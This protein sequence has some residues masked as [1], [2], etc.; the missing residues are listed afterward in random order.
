M[1][2]EQRGPNEDGADDDDGHHFQSHVGGLVRVSAAGGQP[3]RKDNDEVAE[4]QKRDGGD[5]C[6]SEASAAGRT[7]PQDDSD[8]GQ[9]SDRDRNDQSRC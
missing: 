4:G 9:R 2:C 5:G 1:P 8:G 7:H 3:V 6:D